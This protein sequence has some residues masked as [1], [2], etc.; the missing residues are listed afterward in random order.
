M[1]PK[2]HSISPAILLQHIAAGVL[3]LSLAACTPSVPKPVAPIP[4]YTF[5]SQVVGRGAPMILVPGL[6]S[7]SRVWDGVVAHYRT[8]Y[9]VHVLQL[10]GFAGQ[11]AAGDSAVL[12]RV[13]NDIQRYIRDRR[14]TRPVIV[15]HSIG[16]LVALEVAARSSAPI[17]AVVSVDGLPYAVA[18]QVPGATPASLRATAEAMRTGFRQLTPQQLESQL[19]QGMPM[20]TSTPSFADTLAA[21]TRRSDPAT[22][23]SVF[24]EALLTDL[25]PE[26]GRIT[27][28]VL[29]LGTYAQAA[30]PAA[31]EK[32]RVAYE[33][34]LTAIPRHE[35]KMAEHSKHFI[36]IDDLPWLLN[37]MDAFL[38]GNH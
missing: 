26:V 34:Q 17:G 31:R 3:V 30:D 4:T 14:L 37:A 20:M 15:G 5:T 8:R 19:R 21:W 22:V 29:V 33:A 2:L 23:G 28:P 18:V 36:M 25:R 9:E 7:S 32:V 27:A 35:L 16:G 6:V 24:A 10:P 13:A 38:F 12:E 11:P 1:Q